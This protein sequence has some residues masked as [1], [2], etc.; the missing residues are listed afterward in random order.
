MYSLSRAGNHPGALQPVRSPWSR[1]R[2]LLTFML[3]L[4]LLMFND[5]PAPTA[6]LSALSPVVRMVELILS[7][8]NKP[9][10]VWHPVPVL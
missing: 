10:R 1:F 4:F 2:L 7:A 9:V 5:L 6:P 8:R 3:F